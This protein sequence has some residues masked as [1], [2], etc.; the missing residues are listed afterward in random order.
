MLEFLNQVRNAY[1]EKDL[2]GA[3]TSALYLRN[4]AGEFVALLNERHYKSHVFRS[5]DEVSSF[6]K[7]PRDFLKLMRVLGSSCDLEIIYKAAE[8]LW[9]NILELSESE[10]IS[11]K[12][13]FNL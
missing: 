8:E 3:M 5:L 12:N 4:A 7:I 1:I 10:G 6:E 13:L 9:R 11:M 2:Y